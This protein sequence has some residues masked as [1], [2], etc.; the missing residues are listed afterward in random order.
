MSIDVRAGECLREV[1]WRCRIPLGAVHVELDGPKGIQ[2]LMGHELP[3][4]C[5]GKITATVNR[6]IRLRDIVTA[7]TD[8]V[9]CKRPVTSYIRA[10]SASSNPFISELVEASETSI[11]EMAVQAVRMCVANLGNKAADGNIVVGFS[12][13]GD[14]NLLLTALRKSDAFS[15]DKIVPVMVLGIEDWDKQLDQARDLSQRLGFPLRVIEATQSA[16]LAGI[17]SVPAALTRFKHEFPSTSVEFFGTWLLRRVL[18]RMADVLDARH[19]FIGANREDTL[20]EALY[21]IANGL[22]PMP[23]PCRSIGDVVFVSPLYLLPKRVVDAAYPSYSS[24]NYRSRSATLDIGRTTYYYLAHVLQEALPGADLSLM[25]GLQNLAS[26][27]QLEWDDN[28]ADFVH[29]QADIS[30]RRKWARV[31]K[32]GRP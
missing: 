13:G 23:F 19:V 18:S 10:S 24:A 8:V 27:G 30:V 28:L 3:C 26:S 2:P 16:S 31:V 4:Q 5:D 12:G 32:G 15:P 22:R 20:A 17:D 9:S 25:S 14:S 29:A 21:C 6:N 7:T 1:L 11:S